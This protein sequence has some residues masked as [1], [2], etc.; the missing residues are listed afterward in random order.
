MTIYEG[1]TATMALVEDIAKYY[2]DDVPS[3]AT[4]QQ[5]LQLWQAN[6]NVLKRVIF[7]VG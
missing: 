5:E 6:G 3:Q 2:A 1:D 7:Q 4:L